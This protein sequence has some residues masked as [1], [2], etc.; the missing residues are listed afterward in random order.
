MT[1]KARLIYNPVSG[2]E[3]MPKNVAD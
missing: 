2:H 1:R 3:Q